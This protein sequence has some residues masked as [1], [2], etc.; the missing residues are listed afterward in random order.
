M[1]NLNTNLILLYWGR[2]LQGLAAAVLAARYGLKTALV[3]DRGCLGG[4]M[5]KEMQTTPIGAHYVDKNFIYRR[6]TGLAEELI[7]NNLYINP[8][9]GVEL[10][11]L[12]MQTA[13]Y[14]EKNLELFLHLA[15][16]TVKMTEDG[17]KIAEVS[18]YSAE[19]EQRIHFR[20]S[21]FA[22]WHR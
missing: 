9:N 8:Q 20:A 7:L 1:P 10:W 22:D 4:N 2:D 13:V 11:D 12:T 17:K 5:S 19:S 21:F 6:E 14:R 3:N 15:I 18:G 16:D